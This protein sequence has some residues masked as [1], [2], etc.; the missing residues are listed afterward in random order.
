MQP[1]PRCP[2]C[3]DTGLSVTEHADPE[4]GP[5]HSRLSTSESTRGVFAT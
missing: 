1:T 2:Q 4:N 5:H 3:Q